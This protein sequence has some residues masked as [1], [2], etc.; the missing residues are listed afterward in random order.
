L[1][2]FAFDPMAV[3]L[4]LAVNVVLRLR[5]ERNTTSRQEASRATVEKMARQ[6]QPEPQIKIVEKEVI[7]E[8]IKEVPVEVI[9][10]VVREVP[11]EVIKEVI[12]E[13]PVEKI[14]YVKEDVPVTPVAPVAPVP[15]AESQKQSNILKPTRAIPRNRTTTIRGYTENWTQGT[16][17]Q[18]K[19]E[20]LLAHY[21]VLCEKQKQ[22]ATLSEVER[23]E[24]ADI[25]E[26]LKKKGYGAHLE[27]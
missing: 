14:V 4:T 7:K 10:E 20:M 5:E 27:D 19:I 21:R 26:I 1:I 12:K 22:G 3:A 17:T 25:K 16:G 13:V 23:A 15:A 9:K 2:I 24:L 11:V 6:P 8:V 18:E